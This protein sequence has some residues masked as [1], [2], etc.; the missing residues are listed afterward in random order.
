MWWHRMITPFIVKEASSSQE[1][2]QSLLGGLDAAAHQFD[3]RAGPLRHPCRRE[4]RLLARLD[5]DLSVQGHGGWH[6]GALGVSSAG[7]GRA[8]A[9]IPRLLGEI[10]L[11]VLTMLFLSERSWKHHYVT[12]LFPYSYLVHEFFSNRLGPRGRAVLVGSWRCRSR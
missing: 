12:L 9:A 7:P 6:D 4:P 11:I 10:A 1:V 5:G 8:T 3:S 2:N